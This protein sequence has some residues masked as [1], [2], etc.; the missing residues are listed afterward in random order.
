VAALFFAVF[1]MTL[2][3][4]GCRKKGPS[5]APQS[6]SSTEAA[7]Q[8]LETL[9]KLVNANNYRAMGFESLDELRS[10][11]LGDPLHVY[12]VRLDQLREYR[13]ESDPDKLLTDIGQE[14]YP[15]VVGGAVRSSVLVAKEREHW[16]AVSFGGANLVKVFDQKRIESS[17]S[18]KVPV[19]AYF[20][21]DVASMNLYFLGYWKENRLTLIPLLGDPQ[22]KF[23][24]GVP[25]PAS[26]AFATLVPAAQAY[27]GERPE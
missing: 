26:D 13:P 15:V 16:S 24:A 20:E 11:T 4:S 23:T 3:L 25:I 8:G 5:P 22:Y 1:S 21:V 9:R 6:A 19:S 27:R 14:L 10:A 2:L 18:A 12:L 17:S 7:K